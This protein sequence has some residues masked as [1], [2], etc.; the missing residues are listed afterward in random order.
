LNYRW[1]LVLPCLLTACVGFAAGI[2]PPTEHSAKRPNILL[3]VLD[4]FGYN[5]LHANGNLDSPT[6]NLDALAAQGTRY[7][8]H[9]ADTTC[10]A[11]RAALMTGTF[12][13]THGLRPNH[14]GLSVG[15]PTIASM[16]SAA[17][18]RTQ[19]IGKW[20]IASATLDQ[21]PS[22]F[23]FTDWFGFLHNNEL[24]GPSADGMRYRLPTYNNPWLR[25][26][27]SP[28]EQHSGH[29]EDIL[30][31][32]AI[33]FLQQQKESTRPWFLNLWYF[34]PHAPIQPN[35]E[36]A[37][38][39]PAT[40]AGAY[41]ALIEQLDY[42]IGQIVQALDRI[43]QTENTLVVVLSDNG[44][45][46]QTMDNNYPYSGKKTE[47]YEGGLRTPM[48]MRWPG[49][50]AASTVSDELVSI[51]DIFPTLAQASKATPP[52]NLIGRSLLDP[53]RAAPPQLYWEYSNSRFHNY[54]ILSADGRW[55]LTN[56]YG[57][58]TLNDL[59]AD[60][61]GKTSVLEQHPQIAERLQ[62]DYLRWRKT[63][64]QVA[65]NYEAVNNSGGAI[66]RGNDLQRSPGYAGFT[67]AIGVTPVAETGSSNQVI[68]EQPGR[69]RLHTD[70]ALALRLEILGQTIA[71]PT[72]QADRCS[73]IVVSSQF[74][75]SP[76]QPKENWSEIDI[77]VNGE[78]VSNVFHAQ[79]ALRTDDY[80]NPTFIGANARGEERFLGQ[81]THPLILNERVVPDEQA[82]MIGN[83]ISGVPAACPAKVAQAQQAVQAVQAH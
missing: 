25:S 78:R 42:N 29:L 57:L 8:R 38:R 65:F 33:E 5:D 21:S 62:G 40:E 20:H 15:T 69:W 14:L 50:I 61:T 3:I 26:N 59:V 1:L 71:G 73:E 6:P 19:H 70:A 52:P 2:L 68:A 79:P 58:R 48:F 43:G 23:G 64:R 72:L 82:E 44:G 36:F 74:S 60:P 63:A 18:Y 37:K 67:F 9:Y 45:T 51:Y 56:F 75:F 11:A 77:Y 24:G 35:A 10:S 27:Q 47:F 16:L 81:L 76:V 46:N 49:H 12:P 41:L 4:D 80:A 17:G 53:Q 13:A 28:L 39:H 54:S 22:Q 30:T 32:R 83:G 66:L 7:T 55:R 34:A 31:A